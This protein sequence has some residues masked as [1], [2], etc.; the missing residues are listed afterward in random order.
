MYLLKSMVTRILVLSLA[1]GQFLGCALQT[2][3]VQEVQ[4]GITNRGPANK[5]IS[6]TVN[7]K[8]TGYRNVSHNE[9]NR[10]N[11]PFMSKK[12]EQA[13]IV[14]SY[15][16]QKI[17]DF[18]LV[19]P[20]KFTRSNVIPDSDG[21][22]LYKIT[23][24]FEPSFIKQREVNQFG[25]IRTYY[26]HEDVTYNLYTDSDGIIYTIT[27]ESNIYHVEL[28]ENISKAE[29]DAI[30]STAC[31]GYGLLLAIGIGLAVVAA[32]IETP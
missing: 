21:G 11:K 2:P 23:M 32:M 18:L 8:A 22:R 10:L 4:H 3:S 20:V 30:A 7:K 19:A 5:P 9:L 6:K 14:Y 25:S 17:K 15:K 12:E 31:L 26:A 24:R 28:L 16:N 27:Q 1:G 29:K 13:K